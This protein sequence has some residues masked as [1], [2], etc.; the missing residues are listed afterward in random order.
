MTIVARRRIIFARPII[1]LAH[2]ARRLKLSINQGLDA[3]VQKSCINN[4]IDLQQYLNWNY[5]WQLCVWLPP[6]V[7]INEIAGI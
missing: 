1:Y 2:R 5:P 4:L 6:I 7:H 3:N